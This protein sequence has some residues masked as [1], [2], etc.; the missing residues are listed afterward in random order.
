MKASDVQCKTGYVH[1]EDLHDVVQDIAKATAAVFSK[2]YS[3]CKAD[4]D[5]DKYLCAFSEVDIETYAYAGA[6]AFAEG[7]CD[8]SYSAA[9]ELKIWM[10]RHSCKLD[11]ELRVMHMTRVARA[12]CAERDSGVQ[13]RRQRWQQALRVQGGGRC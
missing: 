4:G 5:D 9:L 11:L 3:E 1:E 8:S 10:W 6:T 7:W 13:G 2:S 12:G